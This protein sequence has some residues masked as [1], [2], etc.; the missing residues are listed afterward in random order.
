MCAE[1][2]KVNCVCGSSLQLSVLFIIKA[3]KSAFVF[4]SHF[5][6]KLLDTGYN[7]VKRWYTKVKM[8]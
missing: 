5:I 4:G 8:I 7:G 1:S 3:G 6:K 2:L